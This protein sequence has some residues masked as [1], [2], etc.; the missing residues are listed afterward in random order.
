MQWIFQF[1]FELMH[2]DM[3]CLPHSDRDYGMACWVCFAHV[4]LE[5]NLMSEIPLLFAKTDDSASLTNKPLKILISE[6]ES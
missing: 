3:K 2:H 6:E 1:S 4:Q 5:L